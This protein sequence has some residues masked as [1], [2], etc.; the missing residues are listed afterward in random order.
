MTV[1]LMTNVSL[2]IPAEN[3]ELTAALVA[4]LGGK[5]ELQSGDLIT[6]EPMPKKASAPHNMSPRKNP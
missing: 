3:F 4:R 5:R 1:Q 6:A 2:S